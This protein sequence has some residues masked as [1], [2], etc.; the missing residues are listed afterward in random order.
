MKKNIYDV[1]I[2]GGGIIGT[3]IAR[4]LSQY[5]ISVALFEKNADVSF[6]ISKANSGIIHSGFADKLG[7]LKGKL[8]I[9]GNVLYENLCKD[10]EVPFHRIGSLVVARKEEYKTL[11]ELMTQGKKN[12][13]SGLEIWNKKKLFEKEPNLNHSLHYALYAPTAGIISPYEITIALMENAKDNGVEI[14]FETK[15]KDVELFNK[16]L[17]KLK[18]NKGIFKTKFLINS[19]GLYSDNV[20]AMVGIKYFK[21]FPVKGE[22]L[23]F[24]KEI[25]N[26]VNHVIFPTPTPTSK[27]ILVSPTIDGN[28]IIGP[29]EEKVKN[30]DDLKTTSEGL[31]E[32]FTGA[33][34]ILSEINIKKIITSFAGLRAKAGDDFII[35]QEEKYNNFINVAG[36]QSPGLTA[37]P[38]IAKYV[39]KILEKE[40]NL[41]KKRNFKRTRNK[42]LK[43][44]ELNNNER[45]KIIRKNSDYGKIICR[46]EEV[47]LAEV[48]EAIRR[49]AKTLDGIKYRVRC[50]MGRCQGGFCTPRV[51]MTMSKELNID[52]KEI[53]KFGR[54]SKI[55][56]S[57]TKDL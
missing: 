2:I 49:G 46:C 25:G 27:G 38:A 52:P 23:L 56:F 55:L 4:E 15:L 14:L 21:I 44:R 47:S 3:A 19:A 50:G 8:C 12:G 51:L 33:K 43:I 18:T 53:T 57:E 9:E 16:N 20:S 1:C 34:K 6:G 24:D 39:V 13:L 45:E 30:K 28:L 29:N 32:V 26:L 40:I 11:K 41:I 7:S 10:L 54:N 42:I 36:I 22:Y 37:A 17:F 5:E 35:R 48:K 31:K